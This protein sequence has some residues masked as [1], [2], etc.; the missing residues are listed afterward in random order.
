[1]PKI[2]EAIQVLYFPQLFSHLANTA[3]I[4]FAQVYLLIETTF[5]P[6]V[7]NALSL[8][9]D[10]H[11]VQEITTLFRPLSKHS[12]DSAGDHGNQEP[13]HCTHTTQEFNT[14]CLRTMNYCLYPPVALYTRSGVAHSWHEWAL[15]G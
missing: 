2:P 11:L 12:R 7:P 13:T 5:T 9:P 4:N 10:S 14:N 15:N 6:L 8:E 3:K 1:M